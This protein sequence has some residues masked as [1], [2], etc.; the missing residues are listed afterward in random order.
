MRT[1]SFG[2]III[3][4]LDVWLAGPKELIAQMGESVSIHMLA[5]LQ[6][7]FIFVKILL[8]G[9]LYFYSNAPF[10]EKSQLFVVM[11]IGKERWGR[12]NVL[13]ILGSALVIAVFLTGCSMIM[14]LSCGTFETVWGSMDKTLALTSASE[15]FYFGMDYGIMKTFAPLELEIY[16][17]FINWFTFAILGMFLYAGCLMGTKAVAYAVSVILIFSPDMIGYIQPRQVYYNPIAWI[18]SK[19]WR[20]SYDVSR[21][22]VFYILVAQLLVIFLLV[23]FSQWRM[24]RFQ[25]KQY[26]E[27]GE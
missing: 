3:F 24:S 18:Q 26:D 21:P 12:R 11:R 4:I 23:L 27:E 16:T 2:L 10:T 25:W 17:F 7:N 20:L 13:Y 8:L 22:D 1:V 19:N 15:S 6:N 14:L 9:V 5:F